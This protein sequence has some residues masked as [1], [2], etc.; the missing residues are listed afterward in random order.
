MVVLVT[1]KAVKNAGRVFM[2][3]W[4]AN[5]ELSVWGG[6]LQDLQETLMKSLFF[7]LGSLVV[8]T[9]CQ[10]QPLAMD[11][12]ERLGAKVGHGAAGSLAL[13]EVIHPKLNA[14]M[15]DLTLT[16]GRFVN[17]PNGKRE[18][19]PPAF[20]I[21]RTFS[22]DHEGGR[23]AFLLWNHEMPRAETLAIFS[24]TQRDLAQS[25]YNAL[26]NFDGIRIMWDSS[27]TEKISP[28][29]KTK[30]MQFTYTNDK[31]SVEGLGAAMERV[32]SD[33][34]ATNGDARGELKE[35][36]IAAR[37]IRLE[38]AAC[39]KCHVGNKIGD[40]MATVVYAWKPK[41]DDKSSE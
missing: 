34:S 37:P 33:A 3:S 25:L 18:W 23:Y 39:L 2:N 38:N 27:R 12:G 15:Q 4:A 10:V 21:S 36:R 6:M 7:G 24:A 28:F 13:D 35:W 19:R 17:L 22:T 41:M 8:L 16:E 32:S 1:T 30:V 29:A 40:P 26:P 31:S 11:S 20:G 14:L 5:W 9:G